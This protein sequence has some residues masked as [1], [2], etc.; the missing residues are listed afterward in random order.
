[1]KHPKFRC[2]TYVVLCAG[3]AAAGL[4]S[5]FADSKGNGSRENS[6]PAPTPPG[7][8]DGGGESRAPVPPLPSGR[9][10]DETKRAVGQSI[11]DV[12]ANIPAAPGPP[13]P[14]SNVRIKVESITPPGS[15]PTGRGNALLAAP[16]DVPNFA[17]S[18]RA[19]PV[20]MRARVV[21][22]V[23]AR[24]H[25]AESALGSMEKSEP[26]MSAAGRAQFKSAAE[27]AKAKAKALRKS[28]QAARKANEQE[29]ESA[30]ARLAADYE[31]YAASLARIDQ[32]D[33]AKMPIR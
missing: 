17:P 21:A 7:M 15:L 25:A 6:L 8:K 26:E 16:L 14:P 1:M 2:P 27:D 3:L 20:A 5:V 4:P 19:T 9:P 11:D 30:R 29:W 18:V 33:G 10:F 12:R 28:A 22:D 23:E 24:I 31:A 32:L 13:A